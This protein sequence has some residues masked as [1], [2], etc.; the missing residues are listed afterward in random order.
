M[1]TQLRIR[2]YFMAFSAERRALCG[3]DVVRE[4]LERYN[5]FTSRAPRSLAV[6]SHRRGNRN[7][8]GPMMSILPYNIEELCAQIY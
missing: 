3:N 1:L 8:Y 7:A 2:V 4:A 6:R 5:I